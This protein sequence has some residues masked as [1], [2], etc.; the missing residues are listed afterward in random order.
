MA[1]GR[2]STGCFA[3]LED[4]M[5]RWLL[6]PI[7]GFLND[8]YC[9]EKRMIVRSGSNI[10]FSGAFSVVCKAAYE[11]MKINECQAVAGCAINLPVSLISFIFSFQVLFFILLDPTTPPFLTPKQRRP[12]VL[13]LAVT[14][15]LVTRNETVEM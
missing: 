11:S 8:R 13:T 10:V 12:Q 2:G 7:L 1:G 14:L 4:S 9:S 3:A 15:Q 5:T 6:E